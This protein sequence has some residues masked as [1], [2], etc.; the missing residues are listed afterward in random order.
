MVGDV[1]HRFAT[2]KGGDRIIFGPKNYW[3]NSNNWE[4]DKGSTK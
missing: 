3:E 2:N 4:K 1:D